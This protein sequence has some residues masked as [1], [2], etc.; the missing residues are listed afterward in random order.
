M[1][2]QVQQGFTLIELMIVVAIIGILASIAIPAYQD[3]IAR[4]QA[5]EAAA[6]L[7]AGKTAIAEKWTFDGE[8]YD[9]NSGPGMQ[10]AG[11]YADLELNPNPPTDGQGL[12]YMATF[13]ANGVNAKLQTKTISMTYDT[14]TGAF[15]WSCTALDDVD[16]VKPAVCD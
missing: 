16:S 15:T 5:S 3:Y 2:S 6:M 12:R 9:E 14:T 11:K 1:K 7:G 4:A 10:W 8:P 13:K